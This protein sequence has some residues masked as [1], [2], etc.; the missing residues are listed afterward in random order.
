MVSYIIQQ[1]VVDPYHYY[2]Y[3]FDIYIDPDWVTQGEPLLRTTFSP[4]LG[5]YTPSPAAFLQGKC[6]QPTGA[7]VP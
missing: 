2:Y 1:V 3:I 6:P 5:F 4:S 7:R